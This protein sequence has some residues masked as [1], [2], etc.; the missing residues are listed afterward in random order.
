M[1]S[2]IICIVSGEEAGERVHT[3]PKTSISGP[4]IPDGVL[5]TRWSMSGATSRRELESSPSTPERLRLPLCE[6]LDLK[7]LKDRSGMDR[8]MTAAARCGI[9]TFAFCCLSG[10]HFPQKRSFHP[11]KWEGSNRGHNTLTLCETMPT[12]FKIHEALP[13]VTTLINTKSPI[14]RHPAGFPC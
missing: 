5:H 2:H 8:E 9:L 1:N 3:R 4:S 7:L 14:G 13:R 10:A 11:V 6:P 12:V